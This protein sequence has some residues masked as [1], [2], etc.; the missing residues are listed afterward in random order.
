MSRIFLL[1]ALFTGNLFSQDAEPDRQAD[2]ASNNTDKSIDLRINDKKNVTVQIGDKLDFVTT[3]QNMTATQFKYTARVDGNVIATGTNLETEQGASF[4]ILEV[5]VPGHYGK[6]IE[7][8]VVTLD[9]NCKGASSTAIF[10]VEDPNAFCRFVKPGT[11]EILTEADVC[12]DESYEVEFDLEGR[13]SAE[14]LVKNLTTKRQYVKKLKDGDL[15]SLKGE[16]VGICNVTCD[17]N[18]IFTLK[19]HG[20]KGIRL[21]GTPKPQAFYTFQQAPGATATFEAIDEL[22]G[23]IFPANMAGKV[24]WRQKGGFKLHTTLVFLARV[25]FLSSLV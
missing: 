5:D 25:L 1:F 22:T 8:T 9:G 6:D 17:G 19:V 15:F 12:E 10:K 23:N 7:V 20:V 24:K 11:N 4:S 13:E 3:L 21:V 16:D 14:I 18:L 2:L